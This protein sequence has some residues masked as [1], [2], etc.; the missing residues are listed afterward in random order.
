MSGAPFMGTYISCVT[1]M[2]F[3]ISGTHAIG[4]MEKVT[5]LFLTLLMLILLHKSNYQQLLGFYY[6]QPDVYIKHHHTL[7]FNDTHNELYSILYKQYFPKRP[8]VFAHRKIKIKKLI[9]P[10]NRI[11]S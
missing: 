9:N 3:P 5:M 6:I 8:I 2:A 11:M 10:S 1:N 7:G 4:A